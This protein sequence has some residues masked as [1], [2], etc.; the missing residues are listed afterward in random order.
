M[1]LVVKDLNKA[2]GTKENKINVLKDIN[3]SLE[4]GSLCTLLGPSGSGKSTL[5]NA[6]G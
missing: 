5:L 1:F 4:K 2:Y 6:I 3:F